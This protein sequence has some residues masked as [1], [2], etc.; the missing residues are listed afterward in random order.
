[1]KKIFA[2]A[3]MAV[4]C[5]T[6]SA[7]GRWNV[8][9]RE[10]DPLINQDARDVFIYDSPGVGSVVVW[11]WKKPNFRLITDN[12]FFHQKTVTGVGPCVPVFVGFYD[13]QGN[14][15]SKFTLI[16]FIEDNHG[17]KFISTG[18]YYMGGRGNIRKAMKQ[19]K[20]GDGYLRIVADLY[21]RPKFDIKITPFQQ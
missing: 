10:A 14:M 6:A 4:L 13:N 8:S 9:H 19:M 2:I 5:M 12:G 1:M 7:Q 20:S 21:D 17:F 15:K 18:G 3:L 11:D 16:M